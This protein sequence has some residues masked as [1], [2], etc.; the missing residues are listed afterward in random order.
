MINLEVK[1]AI[2]KIYSTCSVVDINGKSILLNSHIDELEG[3][4]ILGLLENHPD[5]KNTIEIGF[6]MGLSAMHICAVTSERTGAMHTIIDPF[7]SSNWNNVGVNNL[8][9]SG[10]SNFE[11]IEEK[12]E[13]ALPKLLSEG[14]KFDFGLIDGW[15]TFDHTLLDF[16]YLEKMIRPGGIIAID[17]V[18]MPGINKVV[19]YILNYPNIELV[20][21]VP[22]I[23]KVK[24]VKR[25]QYLKLV[26]NPIKSIL[27]K[28]YHHKVFS[29]KLLS[30][31]NEMNLY[32]SM[33]FLLKKF[34]DNRAW[35]WYEEF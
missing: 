4:A 12:S 28:K 1:K 26:F 27:P 22:F 3:K 10:V 21:A 34:D 25:D 20:S 6:A 33:V 14:R 24:M 17:D 16:F 23:Q 19:R 5:Y 32:S 11:L 35:N 9:N 13:I 18:M 15:H 30:P 8:V 7:Q 29:S 2:E 31:D